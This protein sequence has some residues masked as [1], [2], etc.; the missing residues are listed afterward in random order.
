MT[1]TIS[2]DTAYRIWMAHNQIEV[3]HKL[4]DDIAK[5]IREGGDP[6]PTDPHNRHRRGYTLGVPSGSGERILGVSPRL[7]AAVVEAHIAEKQRDLI[8]A[9]LA[10]KIELEAAP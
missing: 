8:E 7:T 2:Q 9:T 6:T 10:A 1:G 3:G 5:T 4:L